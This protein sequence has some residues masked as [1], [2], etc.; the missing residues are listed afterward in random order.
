[1]E[2]IGKTLE[3]GR[4]IVSKSLVG[5]YAFSHPKNGDTVASWLAAENWFKNQGCVI[6]SDEE[7]NSYGICVVTFPGS[8]SKK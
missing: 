1:M 5:I 6:V 8:R 4:K 7:Y 3:D 2:T